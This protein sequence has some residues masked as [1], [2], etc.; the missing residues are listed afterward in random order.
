MKKTGAELVKLI[1]DQIKAFEN[2]QG[3]DSVMADDLPE[4]AEWATV[5]YVAVEMGYTKSEVMQ[6]YGE[7]SYP[8][9]DLPFADRY[10][11]AEYE[12]SEWDRS[13]LGFGEGIV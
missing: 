12:D 6:A 11:M 4:W 10:E 9:E 5:V 3:G 8:E 7:V 2:S 1:E 13:G